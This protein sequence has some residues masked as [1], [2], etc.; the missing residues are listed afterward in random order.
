M[1]GDHHAGDGA[2]S[3]TR[4]RDSDLLGGGTPSPAPGLSPSGPPASPHFYQ[5]G[6]QVRKNPFHLQ[7]AG[8]AGEGGAL[9]GPPRE[10]SRA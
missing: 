4:P 5:L 1:A 2:P 7:G 3:A 9:L 6:H 10:E 8:G